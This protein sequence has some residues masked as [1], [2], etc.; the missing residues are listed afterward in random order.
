MSFLTDYLEYG[1]ETEP[2]P[3][4]HLFSGLTALSAIVSRRV[5]IPMGIFDVY[6]NLYVTLVGPPASRKTTAM[7]ICKN[8]LR[9][10]NKRVGKGSAAVPLAAESQ[11]K[12][13]VIQDMEAYSRHF[14][15][16]DPN[17]SVDAQ[18]YKYCPI[19]ICVTELSNFISASNPALMVDFLTTIY[20]ESQY[21]YK[22]KNK[23]RQ[24]LEGPYLTLLGCTTP[25]WITTWMQTDVI[26]GGFSRRCL[27]VYKE[28]T[29]RRIAL[30][31]ITAAQYEAWGRMLVYAHQLLDVKGAFTWE[32]D[33]EAYLVDW[34]ENYHA[35]TNAVTTGYYDSKQIQLL[36]VAMLVAL[37]HKP[38]LIMR[39]CYLEEAMDI[40]KLVEE[41]L[42]T[43]FEGVGKNDINRVAAKILQIVRIA[44]KINYQ[45]GNKTITYAHGISLKEIK[46]KIFHDAQ[47]QEISH[48]L[49]YLKETDQLIEV[50][51]TKT[52]P[53]SKK[54]Y[55]T[56]HYC[57]K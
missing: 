14:Q 38:E 44:P 39:K 23:G 37:S 34:Y 29:G 40:L 45:H 28:R 7:S 1:K 3:D 42:E 11:T 22:T 46:R 9:A 12:E 36:K 25:S 24:L 48:A 31:K 27:F 35:P 16:K 18:T 53:T 10:L 13:A 21:E 15:Y 8:F 20:D 5:W 17:G 54:R 43:V 50:A 47:P 57:I 33:A 32:P 52:N 55:A 56:K 51:V 19:A 4:F 41:N 30:P 49:D 2:H 6:P 26:S